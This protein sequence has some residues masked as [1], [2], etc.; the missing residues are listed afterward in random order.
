MEIVGDL[1]S[2]LRAVAR[3]C[4]WGGGGGQKSFPSREAA[5]RS[6]LPFRGVRG[7]APPE[8][9]LNKGSEIG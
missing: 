2:G 3:F 8:N 7:H 6:F 4:V 1:F 5:S 9:F